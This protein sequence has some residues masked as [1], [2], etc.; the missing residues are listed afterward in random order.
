LFENMECVENGYCESFTSRAK[1][2]RNEELLSCLLVFSLSLMTQ[3]TNTCLFFCPL[4]SHFFTCVTDYFLL[5]L[6][7]HQWRYLSLPPTYVRVASFSQYTLKERELHFFPRSYY[8]LANLCNLHPVMHFCMPS[9]LPLSLLLLLS[10]PFLL[11]GFRE[12]KKREADVILVMT[13][14]LQS[15]FFIL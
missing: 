6:I 14:S 15:F 2:M 4:S 1:A 3:L 12:R 13:C 11:E 10:L 5:F 8:V 7:L 9:I